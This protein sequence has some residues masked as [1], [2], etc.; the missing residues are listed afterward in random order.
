ME[1]VYVALSCMEEWRVDDEEVDLSMMY[2]LLREL[3]HDPDDPWVKETLAW[4]N[5][6]VLAFRWQLPSPFIII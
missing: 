4:W 5:E 1:Q 6:Y 2:D 3:F